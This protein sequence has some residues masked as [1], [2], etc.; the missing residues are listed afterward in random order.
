VEI[1][2]ASILPLT[3]DAGG[4]YFFHSV[5]PDQRSCELT[6]ERMVLRHV[7]DGERETMEGKTANRVFLTRGVGKHK[8]TLAS[9]ELALRARAA[10][11][12][13]ESAASR[14]ELSVDIYRGQT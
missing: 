11:Q 12:S 7:P 13:S 10:A 8:E 9:F 4:A 1:V 6:H 2:P 3:I 14:S 5:I